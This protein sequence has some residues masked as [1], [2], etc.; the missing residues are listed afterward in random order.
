MCV[1][2]RLLLCF[3][4]LQFIHSKIRNRLSHTK[5]EKS[6][7]V[8]INKRLQLPLDEED[9]G[10]AYATWSTVDEQYD[11]WLTDALL[12]AEEEGKPEFNCF[13]EP[14]EIEARKNDARMQFRME[15]KLRGLYL[16]DEDPDDDDS[17]EP[18]GYYIIHALFWPPKAKGQNRVW[19]ADCTKVVEAVN[20]IGIW[21]P[22]V[23]EGEKE[24]E[25]AVYLVNESL[26]SM[27][28]AGWELNEIKYRR[29]D[30]AADE[31][32]K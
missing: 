18:A 25:T 5:A 12:S 30:T 21:E 28:K 3:L 16:Y 6:L 19:N 7:Y 31:V 20:G 27:I 1:L 22:L 2:L 8:S 14:W 10:F 17:E 29:V 11:S 4:L 24:A 9:P 32:A 23:K 15:Q 26:Y 13:Q